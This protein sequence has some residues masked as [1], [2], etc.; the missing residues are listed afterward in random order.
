MGIE[1]LSAETN[2]M[3]YVATIKI[4]R[5]WNSIDTSMETNNNWN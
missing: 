5:D 1:T 3:G 2:S 4:N